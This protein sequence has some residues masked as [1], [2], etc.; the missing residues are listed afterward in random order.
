MVF[1]A[2]SVLISCCAPSN[3]EDGNNGEKY[4]RSRIT[5]DGEKEWSEVKA[6][7]GKYHIPI[8]RPNHPAFDDLSIM[9]DCVQSFVKEG[10]VSG[11]RGAF[12]MAYIGA[13]TPHRSGDVMASYAEPLCE[14][15]NRLGDEKFAASLS[16]MRTE[17]QSAVFYIMNFCHWPAPGAEKEWDDRFK[18][19]YPKTFILNNNVKRIKWP[20]DYEK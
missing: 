15:R 20:H 9:N 19:E 16:K 1:G 12:L 4:A 13:S 11:I 3:S 6:H 17:V 5:I 18:S 8:S 7:P 10:N 2:M 14:L